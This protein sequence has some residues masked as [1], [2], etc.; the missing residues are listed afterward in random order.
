MMI[1][2]QLRQILVALSLV[3]A[4]VFTTPIMG[5]SIIQVGVLDNQITSQSQETSK[6][7]IQD[8][9]VLQ[10]LVCRYIDGHKRCWND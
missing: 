10:K 6:N 8:H 3:I 4:M 5:H 7:T 2:K 9:I 1:L